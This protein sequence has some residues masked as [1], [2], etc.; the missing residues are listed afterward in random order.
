MTEPTDRW[1]EDG[2]VF[3]HYGKF[4]Y[5]TRLGQTVCKEDEVQVATEDIVRRTRTQDKRLISA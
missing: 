4:Y 5:V 3:I 2:Q 1:S